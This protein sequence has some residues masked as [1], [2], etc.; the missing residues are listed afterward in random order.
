MESVLVGVSGVL[1]VVFA[2][3]VFGAYSLKRWG[4]PIATAALEAWWS[5]RWQ[6]INERLRDLEEDVSNLPRV[7]EEFSRDTKK[8]QE[9]ARWHVRRVKKELER[10]G[11]E[12]AEID[13]LSEDLRSRDGAGGNGQGMLPLHDAMAEVATPAEDPITQ[14]LRMKWSRL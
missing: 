6:E 10:L 7:W 1:F 12:D 14:A 2:V 11:Y 13:R 8:A 4:F 3:A 5:E 9:R